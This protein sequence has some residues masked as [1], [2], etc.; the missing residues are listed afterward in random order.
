MWL[1]GFSSG[2]LFHTQVFS[3]QAV[4]PPEGGQEGASSPLSDAPEAYCGFRLQPLSRDSWLLLKLS[5]KVSGSFTK[6]WK[7]F[8]CLLFPGVYRTYVRA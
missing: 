7:G 2:L 1:Q 6:H 4:S 8:V 3:T 5:A